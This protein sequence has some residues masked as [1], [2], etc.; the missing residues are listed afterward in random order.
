MNKL[1]VVRESKQPPI[2]LIRVQCYITPTETVE[3]EACNVNR[4]AFIQTCNTEDVTDCGPN[5]AAGKD[6]LRE[7]AARLIEIA[8]QLEE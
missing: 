3:I 4:Y 7:L 6:T 2:K 5:I 1:T 8:D